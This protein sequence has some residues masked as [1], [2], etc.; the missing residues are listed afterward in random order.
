MTY[1]ASLISKIKPFSFSVLVLV[2]MMFAVVLIPKEAAAAIV[3]CGFNTDVLSDGTNGGM[4]QLCDVFILVNRAIDYLTVFLSGILTFIL[5]VAGFKLITA[6]G[7]AGQAESAKKM[8]TNGI[9]GFLIVLSSWLIVNTV[10]SKLTVKGGLAGYGIECT[11]APV[12]DFPDDG[13]ETPSTGQCP[14]CSNIPNDIPTN[15]NACSQTPCQMNIDMA[16]RLRNSGVVSENNDGL[17]VSEAWPPQGYSQSDPSGIHAAT[18][19]GIATCVDV[20]FANTPEPNQ[21]SGFINRASQNNLRA[22][23]EVKDEARARVLRAAGVSNVI[24]VSRINR[25]HFSV[26]MCD[27]DS[28]PKACR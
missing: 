18:C 13:G 23:Y 28:T 21:I 11:T 22:V 4:C 15:G 3:Q 6:Q 12:Y 24:V 17:R 20:S 7:N 19:H 5:I 25:E 27:I 8:I 26:Y 2:A 14:N 9:I 10:L 16:N 1:K